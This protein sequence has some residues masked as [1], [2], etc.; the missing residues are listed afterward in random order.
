MFLHNIM[1]R[2][3]YFPAWMDGEVEKAPQVLI[4]PGQSVEI[5]A[6]HFNSVLHA[7]GK[8]NRPLQAL[9]DERYLVAGDAPGDSRIQLQNPTIEAPADLVEE[10]PEVTRTAKVTEAEIPL[11][12]DE[13]RETKRSARKA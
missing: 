8:G 1:Q 12:T 6:D 10:D 13:P 5:D 9:L 2:P 4:D 3:Y 11:T 7:G